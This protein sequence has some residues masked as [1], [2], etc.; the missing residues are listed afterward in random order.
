MGVLQL[1]VAEGNIAIPHS[2]NV[3]GLDSQFWELRNWQKSF[4]ARGL[5]K[6]L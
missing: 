6:T 2:S 1:V 4:Q 3:T 5:S